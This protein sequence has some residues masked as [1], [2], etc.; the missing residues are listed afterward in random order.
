MYNCTD[1][2]AMHDSRE[3]IRFLD[4]YAINND[5]KNS[6]LINFRVRLMKFVLS[7]LGTTII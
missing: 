4:K 1:N 3:K 7:G 5:E 2:W 6:N